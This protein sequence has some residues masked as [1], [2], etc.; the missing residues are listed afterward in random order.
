M[1]III[2]NRQVH[3][4]VLKAGVAESGCTIHVVDEGVDS[5]PIVVQ[6]RCP[7]LPE[8]CGWVLMWWL[9]VFLSWNEG[10][11]RNLVFSSVCVTFID[12]CHIFHLFQDTAES[13]KARVQALE[14]AAFIEAVRSFAAQTLPVSQQQQRQ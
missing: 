3:E 7:V 8:V 13:L 11:L 5:G 2:F 10:I 12:Y 6:K 14:G 4:A 9:C 1:F